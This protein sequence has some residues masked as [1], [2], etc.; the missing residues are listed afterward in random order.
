MKKK[1][2]VLMIVCSALLLGACG[3]EDVVTTSTESEKQ[4][5]SESVSEV[6]TE[7]VD[8][9]EEEI[10]SA[11]LTFDESILDLALD[12]TEFG[13]GE[14]YDDY[15][16]DAEGYVSA[17]S[18]RAYFVD[19]DE[20]MD[21]YLEAAAKEL[22]QTEDIKDFSTYEAADLS[23]Q[24][25]YDICGA[26]FTVGENEDTTAWEMI[27]FF[28]DTNEYALAIKCPVDGKEDYDDAI[29]STFESIELIDFN[30]LPDMEEAWK[31]VAQ[32][33]WSDWGDLSEDQM[34]P[35][36]TISSSDMYDEEYMTEDGCFMY[37]NMCDFDTYS[38]RTPE[39]GF[40]ELAATI[41]GSEISDWTFESDETVTAV[42]TYPAY[43]ASWTA[44][45]SEDMRIYQMKCFVTDDRSYSLTISISADYEDEYAASR[46]AIF[47]S[48]ELV[49][50][51]MPQ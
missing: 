39:E 38:D 23:V 12:H 26:S 4:T 40:A 9:E 33:T 14:D 24:L 48:L 31:P 27:L 42:V 29:A 18:R 16:L 5:E 25:S 11:T 35:Y 36:T 34:Q 43:Q 51:E 19:P 17:I 15:Y 46:D 7:I 49:D 41:S 50:Q 47:G 30:D 6:V 45:G 32:L 3:N 37:Y 22:A 2:L 1:N 44:G 10:P 8:T 21:F 20:D 13:E 28:T